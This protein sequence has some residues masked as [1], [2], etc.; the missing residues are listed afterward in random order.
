MDARRS[1]C[2][3]SREDDFDVLASDS[4]G[5]IVSTDIPYIAPANDNSRVKDGLLLGCWGALFRRLI[6]LH[7][8]G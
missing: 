8:L 4:E 3:V 2:L 1:F 7:G 6:A 5:R